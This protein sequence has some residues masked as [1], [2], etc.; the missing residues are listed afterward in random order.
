MADNE[1]NDEE[2][3]ERI[4]DEPGHMSFDSVVVQGESGSEWYTVGENGVASVERCCH[5]DALVFFDDGDLLVI[6]CHRIY[7]LYAALG[8]DNGD[9]G[10][11]E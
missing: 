1:V 8:D 7:G 10:E 9:E 5:G 6:P 11:G 3:V 4:L 2:L